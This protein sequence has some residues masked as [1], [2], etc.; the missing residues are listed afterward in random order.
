MCKQYIL[1][2]SDYIREN[3]R[4]QS[5]HYNVIHLHF[6]HPAENKKILDIRQTPSVS[7]FADT[8]LRDIDCT[9]KL[10]CRHPVCTHDSINFFP[11]SIKL[12]PVH[13]SG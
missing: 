1:F 6:K 10:S 3:K 9:R 11:V 12:I 5:L 8:L 7:P 13:T 4:E 2:V